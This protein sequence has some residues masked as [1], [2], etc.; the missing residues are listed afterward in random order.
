MTMKN[1]I[2]FE[3]NLTFTSTL[4]EDLKI[5]YF[6]KYANAKQLVDEY[7]VFLDDLVQ[8]MVYFGQEW[9]KV[10]ADKIET[11]VNNTKLKTEIDSLKTASFIN[12]AN[13]QSSEVLGAS[14]NCNVKKSKLSTVNKLNSQINTGDDLIAQKENIE[15]L[16]QLNSL[17]FADNFDLK[18]PT[19]SVEN[20]PAKIQNS[21]I[22]SKKRK[23]NSKRSL[24]TS[25]SSNASSPSLCSIDDS[26]ISS[27]SLE[28]IDE[29]LDFNEECEPLPAVE[30]L[31][32]LEN[33]FL[34]PVSSTQ[35]KRK[36][37][38]VL[39]VSKTGC[40][41][42]DF[43]EKGKKLR[44]T[45]LTLKKV[46]PIV[47]L[48]KMESQDANSSINNNNDSKTDSMWT[49]TFYESR[50]LGK[51]TNELKQKNNPSEKLNDL[52]YKSDNKLKNEKLNK[53]DDLKSANDDDD[54]ELVETS[55][56]LK[57]GSRL[58]S[59]LSLL[60]NS[61]MKQVNKSA[62]SHD[63]Q[64]INLGGKISN[65]S[66]KSSSKRKKDGEKSENESNKSQSTKTFLKVHKPE[67]SHF[68]AISQNLK[69]L[70]SQNNIISDETF[71]SPAECSVNINFANDYDID[72]TDFQEE[73]ECKTP[74]AKKILLNS[75]DIVPGNNKESPEFAYKEAPV[76]NKN[77]KAQ[78]PGWDCRECE[79]WYGNMPEEERK[80]RKN[81]CSKHRGK[82]KADV[83]TPES[84]WNPDFNDSMDSSID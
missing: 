58:R 15:Q 63:E 18:S 69:L 40:S 10:C 66:R 17:D 78:L 22:L 37:L 61:E 82:F 52:L 83:L 27:S 5:N 16:Y 1:Q 77:E 51:K 3:P 20:T 74:P 65:D 75:F 80:K 29:A 48:S 79:Q 71:F 53:T 26:K 32:T 13:K 30:P 64:M 41:M 6:E 47:D 38:N 34:S 46:P 62:P 42:T 73:I 35:N 28:R 39:G 2:P 76:R 54:D 72:L 49:E 50:I 60:K 33:T 68:N 67:N 21:P 7:R 14:P 36:A 45:T 31:K 25:R 44:Q 43:L 12:H 4:T 23:K 70:K 9:S 57:E 24:S 56:A 19:K 84:F 59:K 11:D 8:R 55:P 81:L